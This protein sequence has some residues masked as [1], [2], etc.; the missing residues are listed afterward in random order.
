MRLKG[1]FD[2]SSTGIKLIQFIAVVVVSALAFMFL[3]LWITGG[4]MVSVNSL[5]INQFFQHLGLFVIP[6]IA[7]AYL[8][9]Q[10]PFR[11]LQMQQK[12]T[13]RYIV[14]TI[15]L[16]IAAIPAINLLG[17]IN[18]AIRLPESLSALENMMREM[19]DRPV[20]TDN[21]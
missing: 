5:K 8:W 21:Y 3:G 16:M 1:I 10:T 9:S 13:S 4:D 18:E 19:E 12:P 14:F 20:F 15:I 7:V 17:E 2:K 11:Y 6:P